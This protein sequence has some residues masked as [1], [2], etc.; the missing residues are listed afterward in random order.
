LVVRLM[1]KII[2]IAYIFFFACSVH[3]QDSEITTDIYL[4]GATKG[5]LEISP[6]D[7]P[8]VILLFRN[9]GKRPKTIKIYDY[10]SYHGQ[11]KCPENLSIMVLKP[12]EKDVHEVKDRRWHNQYISWSTLF[13]SQ[14]SQNFK[15]IEPG[16]T[17][18][19]ETSL[20][21]ILFHPTGEP[22]KE[23]PYNFKGGFLQGTYRFQIR[24][25][26]SISDIITLSIK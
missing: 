13:L 18:K 5:R 11:L 17:L 3:A 6:K 16:K 14:D 21:C 25:D 10:D 22:S 19:Y 24:F 1:F 7:D 20:S 8:K 26:T 23:W 12:D 4:D 2:T 15:T 9:L